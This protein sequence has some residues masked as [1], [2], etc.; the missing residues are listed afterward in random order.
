MFGQGT[1]VFG[2]SASAVGSFSFNSPAT[3]GGNIFE[4]ADA[5][6]AKDAFSQ[7]KKAQVRRRRLTSWIA[8]AFELCMCMCFDVR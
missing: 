3:K 5:Q 8:S 1:S 6:K 4:G 2:G 7:L